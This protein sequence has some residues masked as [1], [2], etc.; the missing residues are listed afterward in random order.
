MVICEEKLL[1]FCK[2]YMLSKL[3]FEFIFSG[4]R[5][6]MESGVVPSKLRQ[7]RR[8][9]NAIEWNHLKGLNLTENKSSPRE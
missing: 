6:Q 2:P 9:R 4:R 3:S 7:Q 8:I 5:F 1:L